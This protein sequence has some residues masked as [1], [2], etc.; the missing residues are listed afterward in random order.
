MKLEIDTSGINEQ[1][2]NELQT[3]LTQKIKGIISCTLRHRDEEK[4]LTVIIDTEAFDWAQEYTDL[5]LE[6]DNPDEFGY[7]ETPYTI[8]DLA[9]AIEL[10]YEHDIITKFFKTPT[11]PV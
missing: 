1:W 4:I 10:E 11:F 2:I 8:D 7:G 5:Q 3:K 9:Q 6:F